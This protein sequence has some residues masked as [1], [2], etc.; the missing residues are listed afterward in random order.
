MHQYQSSQQQCCDEWSP[1][2]DV[3]DSVSGERICTR[4]GRVLESHMMFDT[5]SFA[6]YERT[7]AAETVLGTVLDRVRGIHRST[8]AHVGT[9][10]EAKL[11]KAE[12]MVERLGGDLSLVDQTVSYAKQ[13]IGDAHAKDPVRAEAKLRQRAAGC[14]YFA[15]KLD[16]VDRGENEIADTLG[17]ERKIL[18]KANKQLR[19]IL[20][21]QPYART[22]L[23]GIRPSALIPRMLQA[24]LGLTEATNSGINPA[25]I[26]KKVGALAAV[27]EKDCYLE[28]KKPQSVCAA[29]IT[30]V[31]QEKRS[32]KIAEACGV[33][34]GALDGTLE[35]LRSL[36]NEKKILL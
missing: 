11:L 36:V 7:G 35:E 14:L 18:Q 1:E 32:S 3:I 25:Q 5:P 2:T 29:M 19:G 23:H 4:C 16:G 26:R 28:G 22:M 21:D 8:L 13:L 30:L 34:V 31:L 20:A 10:S 24:V 9:S 15:C 27:V 12:K 33:S 6:D 17:M